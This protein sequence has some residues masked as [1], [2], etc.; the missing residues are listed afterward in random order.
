M[1][2]NRN[3]T[4]LTFLKDFNFVK[5]RVTKEQN[6]HSP[7]L[8]VVG[9]HQSVGILIEVVQLPA[10]LVSEVSTLTP[11][12]A[13]HFFYSFCTRAIEERTNCLSL[14]SRILMFISDAVWRIDGDGAR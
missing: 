3:K 8:A 4:T 10:D 1:I 9:E 13:S 7:A 14:S 11:P 2:G 12:A 5:A 6:G